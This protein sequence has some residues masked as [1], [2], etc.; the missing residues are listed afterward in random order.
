MRIDLRSGQHCHRKLT[1]YGHYGNY[2]QTFKLFFSVFTK[3]ILF[4]GCEW[5]DGNDVGNEN[6]NAIIT[7]N[8]F[9]GWCKDFRFLNSFDILMESL[10]CLKRFNF[11]QV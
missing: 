8:R 3:E 10:L 4:R 6:L 2:W 11:P 1:A 5:L 7:F 9:E